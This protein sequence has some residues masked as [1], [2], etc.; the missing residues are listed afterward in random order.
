MALFSVA[1]LHVDSKSVTL[2]PPNPKA[3][4]SNNQAELEC[5]FTEQDTTI[6]S[7]T[8]ITW[9][10]DGKDVTNNITESEDSQNSK[11]TSKLTLPRTE[12][13]KVNK[14]RCSAKSLDKKE[15]ED[16]TVHKGGMSLN[17]VV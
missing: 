17:N 13:Q 1:L 15:F 9:Q 12:W 10:I 16:L 14:V 11:K 7:A 3:F 5:I 4:F 2:K 8:K 6:M